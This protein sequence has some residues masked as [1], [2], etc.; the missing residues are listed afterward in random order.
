MADE[1][2]PTDSGQ[3]P[4]A[5]PPAEPAGD[6]P[7]TFSADYVKELRQEAAQRRTALNEMQKQYD[8]L[9]SQF[10]AQQTE[11][12]KAKQAQLKEQGKYKELFDEAS[13]KLASFTDLDKKAARLQ[14]AMNAVLETQRAGVPDHITA[15]LDK[16]DPVEQLEW[17][18]NYRQTL[19]QPDAPND[20]KPKLQGFNPQGTNGVPETDAQRIA[21]L[22]QKAGQ[23]VSVFGSQH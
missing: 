10:D 21:R 14:E 1:P 18:A 4:Q 23:M 7:E 8:A 11:Q 2:T 5:P 6:T 20:A 12:E 9:K 15:L 16:L 19:Q 22:Q 3:P 13:Q 17:L